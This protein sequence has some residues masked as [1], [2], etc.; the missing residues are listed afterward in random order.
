[1]PDAHEYKVMGMAPYSKEK[2][3]KDA[4]NVFKE[5]MYI[6]GLNFKWNI[7]PKDTFFWYKDRLENCRFD[8]IAGGLQKYFEE[9][10]LEYTSN[11]L[12][13]YKC[14]QL[15]FSGGLSMNVKANMLIKDINGLNNMFV[16]PSGGDE[17]LAIGACYA[18]LDQIE[19]Q[20]NMTALESAYLGP[21]VKE[22]DT[23]EVLKIANDDGFDVH[24]SDNDK[25]VELL[26]SGKVIGRC[27]GRMEFG[28]RSL[29]N[30]SII[31]DARNSKII[32]VINEKIKNRDF[33]M[34]FAPS[35]IEESCDDLF[36]NFKEVVSTIYDNGF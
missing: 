18:Y 14:D 24:T 33:W 22:N 17:S 34:P 20:H 3:L 35:I 8:G 6:D 21:N 1:M 11:A 32:Q 7:K 12:S 26:T 9:I 27:V 23:K 5:G 15:V 13:K 25:I 2:T 4:Y 19:D 29:G 16:P 28:A 36:K 30:R 10:M 31:A